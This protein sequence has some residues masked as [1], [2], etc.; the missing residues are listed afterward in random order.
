M[1]CTHCHHDAEHA[2]VKVEG[3]RC[4]WCGY[5]HSD[6]GRIISMTCKELNALLDKAAKELSPASAYITLKRALEELL[7][8]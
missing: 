3:Q 8:R 6:N 4:S 7:D 1:V 2:P 5:V